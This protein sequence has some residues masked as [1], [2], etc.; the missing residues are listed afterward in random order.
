MAF[1]P[2]GIEEYIRLHMRSN[3]DEDAEG[4]R[5][6][7]RSAP[8]AKQAGQTCECGNPIWVV[9]SATAGRACFTCITLE[10]YPDNDYEIAEA[11]E[12]SDPQQ[13]AAAA[14]RRAGRAQTAALVDGARG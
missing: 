1:V 5:D 7:L 4:L 14:E 3:A 2:I 12:V 9:G 10:A 11:L 13:A 6:R 8:A